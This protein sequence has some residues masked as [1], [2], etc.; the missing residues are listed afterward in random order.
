MSQPSLFGRPEV[1]PL[2]QPKQVKSATKGKIRY[3]TA[4]PRTRMRCVD[5]E[6]LDYERLM[7]GVVPTLGIRQAKFIRVQD[8]ERIPL[9]AEHKQEREQTEAAAELAK[10]KAR[11]GA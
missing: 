7:D 3:D 5:C 4:G 1:K 8:Y 9:C 10:E 6:R 2:P 11:K